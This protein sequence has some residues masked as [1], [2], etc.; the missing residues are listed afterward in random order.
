MKHKV[1]ITGANSGV[2]KY[3]V[4]KF[5]TSGCEVMEHSG[6][7]HFDL[8]NNDDIE[9]LAKEAIAFGVNVL[10]NNAAIVCPNIPFNQYTSQKINDMLDVNLRS[11]ILLSHYLL[12]HL[13]HIININSM[14]GLE[15]KKNRSLYSATKW[16]LR[17]FA[18][19][20]KSEQQD[21]IILDVYPSNIRTWPER[22]DSMQ[23]E[24]VVDKIYQ[25]FINNESNL[26]IDGRKN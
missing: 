5:R 20:F 19:S 12:P 2:G 7:K 14:V 24:E 17:G 22:P 25:A 11:P 26:V 1:L 13:T 15:I 10:I 16:G 8:T 18:N 9:S 6:R 4:S 21:V 23:V 3:L